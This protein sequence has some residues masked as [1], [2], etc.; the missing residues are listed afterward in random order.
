C[1]TVAYAEFVKLYTVEFT[2]DGEIVETRN[3]EAGEPLGNYDCPLVL[4]QDYDK[5]H[6]FKGWY[7]K[8][9][10]THYSPTTRVTKNVTLVAEYY[11]HSDAE[12]YRNA[13]WKWSEPGH[14]YIHYLRKD[15]EVY[16]ADSLIYS[17][18]SYTAYEDWLLWAW[19]SDGYGRAFEPIRKGMYGIVYD[20]DMKKTYTDGGWNALTLTHENKTVNYFGK[21]L[22]IQFFNDKSRQSEVYW[23]ND[24]GNLILKKSLV[25]DYIDYGTSS[26]PTNITKYLF[27]E[28]VSVHLIFT[29]DYINQE[30]IDNHGIM[31]IVYFHD[32][33]IVAY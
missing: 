21:D 6:M 2:V 19:P 9:R 11:T 8:D 14:L 1:N 27:D 18:M 4:E 17:D 28:N 24:G 15:G 25:F 7:E 32:R 12:Y 20:I 33:H 26:N 3:V 30:M 16:A 22:G 29:Y 23:E 31:M 13:M 5:Y 10:Y